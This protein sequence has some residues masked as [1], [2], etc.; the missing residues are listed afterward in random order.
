MSPRTF[1][2]CPI[3][4]HW[5]ETKFYWFFLKKIWAN[6]GLF[7]F[8]FVFFHIAQLNKL[9]KALIVCSGL[10][11]RAA[12]WK[13]RPNPLSYGI[14]FIMNDN[15]CLKLKSMIS[16]TESDWKWLAKSSQNHERV[17]CLTNFDHLLKKIFSLIFA[18]LENH[19]KLEPEVNC[20]LSLFWRV[21]L[22]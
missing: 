11:P 6:P 2:N 1:K 8:I 15:S 18:K 22:P 7:L 13:A 16:W 20:V 12:G 10:K 3:W 14:N 17:S 19:T 5:W 9:M 21:V 4:S